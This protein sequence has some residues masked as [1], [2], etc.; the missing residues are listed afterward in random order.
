[1]PKMLPIKFLHWTSSRQM[2]W[3]EQPWPEEDALML[4]L[5]ILFSS[6][7]K[8]KAVETDVVYEEVV[9]AVGGGHGTVRKELKLNGKSICHAWNN[10]RPCNGTP[11]TDGCKS[12]SGEERL[13]KCSWVDNGKFCA[14]D[15]K[16]REHK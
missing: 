3:C 13:H 5:H 2:T 11:I 9:V 1:M 16:K 8:K 12:Q 10:L 14:K 15:H 4:F 6:M 7:V